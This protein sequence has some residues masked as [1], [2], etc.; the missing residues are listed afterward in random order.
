M[1]RKRAAWFIAACVAGSTA[2]TDLA[3]PL[4]FEPSSTGHAAAPTITSIASG[5]E[6]T[7]GGTPAVVFTR[8]GFSADASVVFGETA[9]VAHYVSK[10]GTVINVRTP[11]HPAGTVD[12]FLKNSDG[13]IG[14]VPNG[15]TYEL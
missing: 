1:F 14:K 7:F 5:A 6:V 4:P 10:D 11:P 13:Q 8:R 15:Y 9:V 3:C 12:V 2:C